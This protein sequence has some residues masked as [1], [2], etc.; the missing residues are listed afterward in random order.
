MRYGQL[1]QIDT[2]V[3]L[4]N[5]DNYNF[6][7][8]FVFCVAN[9]V[10]YLPDKKKYLLKQSNRGYFLN[11][12]NGGY[13]RI[14]EE[15]EI[16]TFEERLNN[17]YVVCKEKINNSIASSKEKI[18]EITKKRN[19]YYGKIKRYESKLESLEVAAKLVKDK[20]TDMP[21]KISAC[22]T[23]LRELNKL[24]RDCFTVIHEIRMIIDRDE[25]DLNDLRYLLDK[26]FE[27]IMIYKE[28][29][30][31]KNGGILSAEGEVS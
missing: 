4:W 7:N 6:L 12:D 21:D 8:Q 17:E 1:V 14:I 2:I 24:Q 30:K 16:S 28:G 11:E 15:E 3:K 31:I 13:F 22:T 26:S 5:N 9:V 29:Q 10:Q 23:K 19:S 20:K 18:V 25:K 27:T